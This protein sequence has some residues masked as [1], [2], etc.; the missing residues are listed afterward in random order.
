MRVCAR[1][2]ACVRVRACARARVPVCARNAKSCLPYLVSN[3]SHEPCQGMHQDTIANPSFIASSRSVFCALSAPR[4]ACLSCA[5]SLQND[6]LPAETA[7][8]WILSEPLIQTLWSQGGGAAPPTNPRL[9]V[10]ALPQPRVCEKVG[11]GLAEKSRIGIGK[12]G[13]VSK[14][15]A[16]GACLRYM[17]KWSRP[18]GGRVR[19]I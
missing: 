18:G 4:P 5:G 15:C 17:M 11:A 6:I 7:S 9:S 14:I 12:R 10:L 8:I 3:V 19:D 1:A 2:C 13:G 16:A